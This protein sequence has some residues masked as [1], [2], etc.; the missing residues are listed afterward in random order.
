MKITTSNIQI[1]MFLTSR[2][3]VELSGAG[4]IFLFLL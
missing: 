2:R 3:N 4:S 1:C